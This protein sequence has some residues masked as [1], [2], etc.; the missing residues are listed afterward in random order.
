MMGRLITQISAIK[1]CLVAGV[2]SLSIVGCMKKE[3]YDLNNGKDEG[4]GDGEV[5]IDNYFDFSTRQSVQLNVNYGEDC[6]KAYFEVYAENPLIYQEEG[7]QV[8]KRND[9]SYLYAGFADG[10]GLYSRNVTIPA[11]VSEVYIYS[12][13]F[14]VPKLYKT[15]VVGN[16][17]NATISFDNEIDLST[18]SESQVVGARDVKAITDKVPNVL[19]TW[20]EIGR[21]SYLEASLTIKNIGSELKKYITKYFPEGKNNSK[22]VYI[23]HD[24]DILIK[25]KA[26]IWV[27]YFG[28]DTSA[29]SVFAYYCYRDG[30]TIDEIK[31][32]VQSACVI[33][34][35]AC[36][37]RKS[38]KKEI[39]GNYSGV[40]TYLRYI[41][42]NGKLQNKESGFPEGT[43]IGFF[44]W[45]KGFLNT[46]FE[47]NTFYSTKSL[48]N[49]K[50]S[51]TAIFAATTSAGQRY[52]V[53]TM[54]DYT[55]TD[56][57]DVAFIISSNPIKAI[58]VP[59][60]PDPGEDR[61]GTNNY[62]GLLGFEDNW[63]KQGDY[64]MNDVVI[65]Y[66]SEVTFNE[67]NGII[68]ITDNIK[69]VWT[70]ADFCNGFSYQV[71]F[72]LGLVQLSG[73]IST[74]ADNVINVFDDA[75][76][77]LNVSNIGASQMPSHVSEIQEKVYT[78]SMVFN[79]PYPHRVEPPYNPFIRMGSTEVHLPDQPITTNANNV[80]P[81]EADISDGKTTFF[82]CKDGFP[83]AIHMD[84]REDESMMD[85][86]LVPEGVRIDATYP[87]FSEWV[88]TRNPKEK[89]WK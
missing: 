65:K 80:F 87:K 56:Y 3:I 10:R 69:L 12:P 44:I 23:S 9:I 76:K 1:Y 77:E 17:V 29:Q 39:L 71:P 35:N 79:E 47:K 41:D 85:L 33:F 67:N 24:T 64:D 43:R 42:E 72:D 37:T 26:N 18:L 25:E 84:A 54:E 40:G 81:Q 31:K 86:N 4:K 62:R 59:D 46:N 2:L 45:N 16:T 8:S 63:P 38:D 5:T 55:D 70:G 14:G 61:T 73:G 83:F 21:P 32:A 74:S 27:N 20:D 53:I 88:K 36:G 15:D 50:R 52:N 75:K 7:S 48:N 58:D 49:D 22:S 57:N 51:H 6:P 13:D 30:A 60:A 19:G 78:I 68:G 89:W 82:I 34:P 28:G 66:E 11:S